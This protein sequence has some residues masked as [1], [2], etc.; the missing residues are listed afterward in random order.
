METVGYQDFP[1]LYRAADASSLKGQRRHLAVT[2]FQLGALVTAAAFGVFV[3]RAAGTDM[4][5]VVS[6]VAFGAALVSEVY[7]LKERP[8]RQW[9]AG[10]AVA[11]STKTLTWRYMVGG[12]PLGTMEVTEEQAIDR[13]LARFAE[14]ESDVEGVLLTPDRGDPEQVT[15]GMR[16]ARKLSLE[17]R[18]ESYLRARIGDQQEWYGRKA[19]WNERRGTQWSVALAFLELLGL[20]AGVLKAV[21]LIDIDLLGVVAALA[22]AGAAWVQAKQHQN[23][24]T[25]YAVAHHELATIASRVRL[26]RTEEEWASFVAG[27]E[28]AIS[29][30]HTLWRASHA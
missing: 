10:R 2:R 22:A 25:A 4:A 23:L 7:L 8:D 30:E 20:T 28:D 6:S 16:R 27:S 11:E 5:A 12:S 17:E 1:A 29:R 13:L 18:R 24:A 15:E 9:Y 3:L 21:G 14:I 26:M 19:R